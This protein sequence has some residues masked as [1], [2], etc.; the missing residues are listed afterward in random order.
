MKVKAMK[1]GNRKGKSIFQLVRFGLVGFL[2]T[3]VDYSVFYVMIAF[4]N[5]HKIPAQVVAT[6]IAMCTS[7]LLNRKWTFHVEEKKNM[8]EIA[9]FVVINIVSMLTTILFTC[10]FHDILHVERL[11]D[12]LLSILSVSYRLSEDM[13]VM[14]AKLLSMS[15]SVCVNFF[16]NKFWV[17]ADK[18]EE[19]SI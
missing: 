15:F 12:G 18:K 13:A 14:V 9:K 16:G 4:L 7:Y 6:G 1:S 11:A 3:L 19:K 8:G 5:L 2:N 17:F 10:L